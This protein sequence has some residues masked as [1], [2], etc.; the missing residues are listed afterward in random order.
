MLRHRGIRA[1]SYADWQKIDAA[2]V[3]RGQAAAKP[4]E[5]FA[6]LQEMLNTLSA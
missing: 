3:S 4:R 6:R 1:I 2:E 5:K